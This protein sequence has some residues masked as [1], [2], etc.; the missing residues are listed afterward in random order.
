MSFLKNPKFNLINATI[1]FIFFIMS[2][3]SS[4]ENLSLYYFQ[5]NPGSMKGFVKSCSESPLNY[6][7]EDL[8]FKLAVKKF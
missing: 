8:Q 4:N 5:D 7:I 1:F 6:I 2:N 3:I